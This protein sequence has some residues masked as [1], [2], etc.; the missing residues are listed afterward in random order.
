M[1]G[2]AVRR[3]RLV[4][5]QLAR[6][7]FAD[8]GELVEWMGAVQC[9]DYAGGLWSIGRRL[10]QATE[11]EVERA[12]EERTIVRT[13]PMRG[14]L[15]FVPAPDARWMVRLLAPRVIARS[16][17]RRRQLGIDDAVLRKARAVL[18]RALRDGRRL[19]RP[20]AYGVLARAG[21]TP[22]GQRGIHVLG[23]LAQEGV[24]CFGP[25][26]GRQPT[27]VLLEQWI[28]ASREPS[29]EEA[30]AT[31]ATRYFRSHG[32]ATAHDF[33]WWTG[34]TLNDARDAI[35]LAGLR[36][37]AEPR[38]VPA[39]GLQAV[40]LQAWDEYLVAY[41]D[42]SAA[43]GERGS[44]PAAVGAPLVAVDGVVRGAW[45]R[46]LAASAVRVRLD[47]RSRSTPAERRAVVAEAERYA[48]FLGRTLQLAGADAS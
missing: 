48:A 1:S 8:P 22:Q 2:P 18:E 20:A 31:L 15:H 35:E 5:Q 43:E 27:F 33:A 12:I 29:R 40:F 47:L 38:T 16:A 39:G 6:P 23:H 32:P 45:G 9:Q 36:D 13:W 14:T 44:R 26:D 4:A 3:A 46:S 21:V 30:L 11:A 34:L 37:A 19:T 7:R 17:G 41:K 25:R 24:L 28:A 42:R 10:R